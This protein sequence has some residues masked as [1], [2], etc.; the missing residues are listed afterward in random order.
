M[1]GLCMLKDVDIAHE[2]VT[3]LAT[4]FKLDLKSIQPN[5]SLKD[6]LGLDSVDIMDAVC[7]FEDKFKIKIL[8]EGRR[9][10]DWPTT[11]KELGEFIQKKIS[12]RK[13]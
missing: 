13:G 4:Q 7:L 5:S 1:G 12:Q 11:V 10:N 6:D 8:E 9:D 3:L 2:T